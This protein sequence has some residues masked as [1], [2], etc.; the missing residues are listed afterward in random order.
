VGIDYYTPP[1][2]PDDEPERQ[3]AVELSGVLVGPPDARLHAIVARAARLF[4]APMAGVSIIDRDRQWFAARTG[5]PV[6]ETSRDTS[7]CGHAILEPER[8]LLVPDAHAD[9]RFAGNPLV[10]GEPRIRFYLGA[11]V[12]GGAGRPLGTVC[13]LDRAPRHDGQAVA[14]LAGLAAEVADAIR[15]GGWCTSPDMLVTPVTP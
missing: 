11:V 10:R 12:H 13:V 15:T 7:F 6:T 5:L 4:D 1:G 8:F 9:E 2:R 3:R 14:L